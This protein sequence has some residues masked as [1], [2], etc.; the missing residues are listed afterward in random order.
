MSKLT[1]FVSSFANSIKYAGSMT[2]LAVQNK[3]LKKQVLQWQ[4]KA[5]SLVRTDVKQWKTAWQQT[6]SD[7]PKNYP[8]QFIYDRDVMMDA[9]LVS[10]LENRNNQVL[11]T[12][13]AVKTRKSNERDEEQS[14]KIRSS[15]GVRKIIDTI[16]QSH[17]FGYSLV[18]IGVVQM[19]N[20]N[21]NLT[22][23][24]IP[25]TNVVPQTG[26]FYPDYSEDKNISYRE[27]PEFG[28]YILEFNSENVGLFNKIVPHILFKKFALSCWS[29]LC[30]IYG[31]PP[32]VLK[33]DTQNKSMLNRAKT[34]MMDT[35]AAAWYIIDETE[36]MEWG[37]GVNTNG[38]VFKQ[39]IAA[40]N[41]EISLLISGAIIGQDTANGSRSK[42]ESARSVL[43]DLVQADLKR[44]ENIMNNTVIPALIK[45]GYL[46]GDVVFEFDPTEDL[47]TLWSRTKDSW[48]EYDVDAEWVKNKF[49]IEITGKKQTVSPGQNNL[50]LSSDFF[51]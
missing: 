24:L 13:F 33:T 27:L 9:L 1:T 20:G 4:N 48:Q 12:G 16:L 7:E 26:L 47:D 25:R 10:Q 30:E 39:L 41:N 35:G 14:L 5:L 40:T 2:K 32:R 3:E 11:K 21:Q 38:D 44:V 19:E 51:V 18:E 23:N 50:N 43:E 15:Q 37:S 45:I 34:M 6:S 31:I 29:E 49:G 28:S 22:V 17:Y 36:K 8:L 42:D 46:K